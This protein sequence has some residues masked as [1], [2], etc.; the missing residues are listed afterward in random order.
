MLTIG[1]HT[2]TTSGFVK[3][4]EEVKT[5]GASTFQFFYAQSPWLQGPGA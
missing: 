2:S 5:Y 4:M 3:T 1:Y